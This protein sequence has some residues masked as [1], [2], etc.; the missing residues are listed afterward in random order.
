MEKKVVVWELTVILEDSEEDEGG[1]EGKRGRLNLDCGDEFRF[2]L[3]IWMRDGE[4]SYSLTIAIFIFAF[5][6]P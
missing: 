4:R 2:M 3:M 5:Y 1:R 6:T